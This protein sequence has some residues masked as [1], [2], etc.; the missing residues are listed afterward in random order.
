[1][2][3]AWATDI[4]L[5]CVGNVEQH[6]SALSLAAHRCDAVILSGDISVGPSITTHLRMLEDALEKPI[7]FVLGNHDYYFSDIMGTRRSV[8]DACKFMSYPR[9]LGNVPFIKLDKKTALVGSDGW[10]DGFNGNVETSDFIM[11][12]WLR[13][14]D[15]RPVVKAM[16]GRTILDLP[17]I[18][19]I[20]RAI[21]HASVSHVIKG[22]KAVAENVENIIVVTHVPPFAESYRSEKYKDF[23]PS[24]VMPWYTSKMMGEMLLTAA[25]TYPHIQFTVLS[26]HT[27]SSFEGKILSNLSARVGNSQYGTPQ[28]AGYIDI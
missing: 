9:Y 24:N 18:L 7:Y 4:H 13:I 2:K 16:P 11:N 6:L 12:D 3:L 22:I 1:M 8:V 27:H 26:G 5:D 19:K 17:L 21:C 25:K 23:S 14:E 20:S 28:I 15:F 10:Y